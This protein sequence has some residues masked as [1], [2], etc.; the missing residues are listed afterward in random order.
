MSFVWILCLAALLVI[1]A[2]M[3]YAGMIRKNQ[4]SNLGHKFGYKTKNS[5]A[6]QDAW[7]LAQ[8]LCPTRY[9]VTG[10]ILGV[11]AIAMMLPNTAAKS[12]SLFVYSIT[13]ILFQLLVWGIIVITVENGVRNLLGIKE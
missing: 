7:D 3:I 13:I 2:I 12:A 1:P 4:C 10:I 8:K 6:S 11:I 5:M 9:I